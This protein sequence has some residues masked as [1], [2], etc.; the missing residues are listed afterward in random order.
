LPIC[1]AEKATDFECGSSEYLHVSAE[2]RL[3]LLSGLDGFWTCDVAQ[4]KL[5]RSVGLE[6]RLFELKV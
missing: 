4:A 2:R 1:C 5:A 3:N 6:T